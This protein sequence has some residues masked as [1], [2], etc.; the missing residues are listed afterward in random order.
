MSLYWQCN[1]DKC[2]GSLSTDGNFVVKV[3]AKTYRDLNDEMGTRTNNHAEGFNS[4]LKTLLNTIDE[5]D[6]VVS[7]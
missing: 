6:T 4:K 3:N 1:T 2:S 7:I 5:I